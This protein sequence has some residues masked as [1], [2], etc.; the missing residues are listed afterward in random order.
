MSRT[1][2]RRAL[3]LT[4][5]GALLLAIGLAAGAVVLAPITEKMKLDG[6]EVEIKYTPSA[7]AEELLLPF[8]PGATV[9]DSFTY[10][11]TSAAGKQIL[12]YAGARLV[13]AD[14]PEKAAAFYNDKLPGRPEATVIEDEAGKR[15]VLAVASG[16]EVRSITI[17]AAEGKTHIELVRTSRPAPPS[18][19]K[20]PLRP[21]RR[22]QVT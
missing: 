11:V 13:T 20:P 18:P 10:H 19:T 21:R 2:R 1:R 9:E 17:S 12:R 22:E 4:A 7:S 14:A 6:G 8:Y 15:W 16:D 3:L 5:L